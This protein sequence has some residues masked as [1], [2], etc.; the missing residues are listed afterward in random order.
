MSC[1]AGCRQGWDPTLLWLWH[2]LAFIAL[3]P[4]LAWEP[5]HAVSAALKKKKK[6]KKIK[7]YFMTVSE[8]Q[9]T[10]SNVARNAWGHSSCSVV[11]P[12]RHFQCIG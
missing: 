9:P 11:S 4:P 10:N 3:I 2:R 6:K 12:H 7:P 8:S 1:G 5:P